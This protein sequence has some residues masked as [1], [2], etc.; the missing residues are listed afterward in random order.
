MLPK[1]RKVTMGNPVARFRK[2]APPNR[3]HGRIAKSRISNLS[4]LLLDFGERDERQ[5]SSNELGWLK[6]GFWEC[7]FSK[8]IWSPT[9]L[10]KLGKRNK[11][12]WS[13]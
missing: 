7:K 1:E 4:R 12:E 5:K 2:T 9:S 6:E 11:P 13:S 10:K 3:G 8:G